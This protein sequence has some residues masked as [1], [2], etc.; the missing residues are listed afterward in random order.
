MSGGGDAGR[1]KPHIKSLRA[2]FARGQLC[3]SSALSSPTDSARWSV[4]KSF[5]HR[6]ETPRPPWPLPLE[7]LSDLPSTGLSKAAAPAAALPPAL[8]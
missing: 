2:G 6:S 7:R 5:K 1:R 8:G 4:H 3:L